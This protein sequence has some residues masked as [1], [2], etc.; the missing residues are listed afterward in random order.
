MKSY[1][2]RKSS[3]PVVLSAGWDSEMWSAA[4]EARVDFGFPDRNGDHIPDVRVRML[5]DGERICGLFQVKDR[6]VVA[7]ALADQDMVC[8]DSCVEFFVK[9]AGAE[10][11]FNFEMNCGGTVLLYRCIDIFQKDFIEIPGADMRTIERYHTL[12]KVITEEITEPVTW[13]LGF[14]VPVSFFEKYAGSSTPLSGQQWT[15]N[16]TK[17]ADKC[18]HP[19]WLSW[20]PLSRCS[21]HMPDEF[22]TLI[23][24]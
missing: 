10:C 20:M 17:C 3:V 11:Y 21:Y 12:P 7:R 23:F 2:V 5:H 18:S 6:Y 15:G 8:Q 4:E 14:A 1:T 19:A 9:P 22:G 13:Y 24:E 16:F